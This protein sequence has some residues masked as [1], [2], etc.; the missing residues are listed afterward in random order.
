[1]ARPQIGQGVV[2]DVPATTANIGPGFDCLGAA[3]DLG[4]ASG[5]VNA[6]Q[7]ALRR[8]EPAEARAWIDRARG[9]RG[10]RGLALAL[11]S[12]EWVWACQTGDLALARTL[13]PRLPPASVLQELGEALMRPTV[14]ALRAIDPAQ[15]Q[16]AADALWG[17]SSPLPA[18]APPASPAALADVDTV[19]TPVPS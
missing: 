13:A 7:I 5:P 6:A 19:I 4:N 8:R 16:I 18:E 14:D 2:V 17:T 9:E 3:L 11:T 1:M 10:W 15:A 12:L